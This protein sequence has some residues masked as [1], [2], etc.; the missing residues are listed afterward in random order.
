M[1]ID[2]TEAFEAF[3]ARNRG[4][5]P[6]DS[7][8]RQAPKYVVSASLNGSVVNLTLI[9]CTGSAY[10]CHEWGCHLNLYDGKRWD[11]LRRELFKRGHTLPDRLD[12]HLEVVIEHG[13]LFSDFSKP[14]PSK[15][16]RG[17]YEF[18]QADAYRYDAVVREG[19]A[20]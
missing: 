12:L 14:L 16:G 19:L 6:G 2:I 1:A 11:W 10:C 4:P 8:V 15:L 20:E 18:A 3:F 9:F 13:A 5:V 7:E 17:W